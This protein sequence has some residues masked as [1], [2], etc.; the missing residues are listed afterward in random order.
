MSDERVDNFSKKPVDYVDEDYSNL[1][2]TICD[3]IWEKRYQEIGKV[4]HGALR[5]L[6]D[7]TVDD[8]MCYDIGIHNGILKERARWMHALY[9]N[10]VS[11]EDISRYSGLTV[12]E[13]KKYR[14]SGRYFN[15]FGHMN[16]DNMEFEEFIAK[17][18]RIS[19]AKGIKIGEKRAIKNERI[20]VVKI[21]TEYAYCDEDIARLMGLS[22]DEVQKIK[23]EFS[24]Q[25]LI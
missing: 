22:V 18:V 3:V 15:I 10:G 16:L 23:N 6:V 13:I 5:E 20:R 1:S 21:F 7:K 24:C 19:M 2:N 17:H 8:A 12:D 11:D 9:V 4:I 14:S 25:Q